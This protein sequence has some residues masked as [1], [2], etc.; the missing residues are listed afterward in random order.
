VAVRPSGTEPKLKCYI[1]IRV[2]PDDDMDA[3]RTRAQARLQEVIADA[4]DLLQRGPN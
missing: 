1:E 3:A 2:A 4:G